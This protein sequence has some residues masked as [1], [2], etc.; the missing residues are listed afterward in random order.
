MARRYRDVM[1]ELLDAAVGGEYGDGGWLPSE[2]ELRARFGCGR[3]VLREALRGLQERG[4]IVVHPGRGQQVRQRAAWDTRDADVLRACI[5]RGPDPAILADTIDA[6]AAVE[7][8][9]I[10]RA[11]EHATAGDLDL[12]ASQ[13]S[14]M[15]R[16]LD[17]A[18]ERTADA[19]DPLVEA[20]AW[21][22]H[23]L[24]LLS[25]NP[26]LATLIEPLQLVLAE[27]RRA[28]AADRDHAV[29]RHHR[30]ILEALSSREPELA[31]E[32]VT[33]YARQLARWLGARR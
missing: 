11:L 32:A 7:C 31:V 24:A 16:A 3:G 5:A 1:L 13:V 15:E 10:V 20:E 23:T 8:V 2:P 4:L 21:F 28:H 22:H 12:L 9:A 17:R 25:N 26:Q 14:E 29:V 6:R 19:S 33:A 27:Q 30:R 18:A